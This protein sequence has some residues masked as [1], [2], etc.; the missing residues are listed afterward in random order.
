MTFKIE[1]NKCRY[2]L[3]VFMRVVENEIMIMKAFSTGLTPDLCAYM[4][5]LCSGHHRSL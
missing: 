2:H 1:L 5:S 4:K 3:L